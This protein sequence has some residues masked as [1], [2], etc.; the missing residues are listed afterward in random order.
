[1]PRFT[2]KRQEQILSQMI[3]KVVS[4]TPLSDVSNT[5]V[6]KHVLTAAAR[7]DDEQYYQ[8]SLL[9]LLFSID[10]ASGD[11]LDERAKE[12][13]P[14][15]ITRNLSRKATG[16]VVIY[17][18]GTVGTTPI[19]VNTVVT[20]TDG[21]SYTTTAAG[22]ISPSSPALVVGHVTGQDSGLIPA[23]A[24]EGGADGNVASGEIVKFSSKP[25]G[26]DGVTNLSAM[27]HGA[28]KELDD[29]FRNR[30]RQYIATLARSTL[31]A[32]ENAVLGAEDTDTGATILFAKAIEDPINRGNV[33]LYI[34]DGTGS[35]S[36]TEAVSGEVITA[37]LAGPPAG[38][39]V[40]GE[41]RLFLDYKP[42]DESTLVLESDVLGTLTQGITGDYYVNPSSGQLNFVVPLVAGEVVSVVGSYTRYTGLIEL[43]QKIVDGMA[44]DRANYPGYRAGGVRVAVTTPQILIQAV[45]LS[46][47]VAEGYDETTVESAVTNAIRDY[48]NSLGISGDVLRTELIRRI[49][50]VSGVYDFT[51]VSPASNVV[52]LDDQ[53]ARTT[54][55]NININ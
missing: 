53:M 1:M 51:L 32:I 27:A 36:T 26:V 48:I 22:S 2:P 50:S 43:A 37:G 24:S 18:N 39:A 7:Q 28:D 16:N 31:N 34:D 25:P 23:I 38:A 54:D 3:A 41:Q 49:K 19:A 12:I 44:S 42:I 21:K 52:L 13:Q 4:R 29:S 40:G 55:A 5:A 30:L 6:I 8:M 9:Q 17:R 11:D 14:A 35:A 33:T 45:E 10:T 15:I 46:I 47:I 20:T